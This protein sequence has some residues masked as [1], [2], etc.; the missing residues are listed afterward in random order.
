MF[1]AHF[2]IIDPNF[3]LIENNAYLPPTFLVEDY[4]ARV[5]HLGIS[6]GALVS[7]SFQ[8]FDQSYLCAALRALNNSNFN[9]V[10]V[11]QLAH[12]CSDVQI[13]FL[14]EQGVRALRFNLYRGGSE[15]A[16]YL[17]SLAKRVHSL[18]GWHVELY[19][20]ADSLVELAGLIRRLPSVSI[21][22]LGMEARASL[23]INELVSEGVMVKASGFGRI[24]FDALSRIE[25]LYG[26]NPK[27]LMFGT[28][29]P[30]TRAPRPFKDGDLYLLRDHLS[31]DAY[32]SICFRNG[33]E[34]Y[35]LDSTFSA[36]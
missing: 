18:V 21:D 17:E 14:H 13:R 10:G 8:G 23:V 26:L 19:V 30:S 27:A 15:S 34:F 20:A 3:P 32:Q 11:T 5:S 22:H 12:D 36:A 31:A 2:H 33:R 28:D 16:Q 4:L 29:L 6:S 24:D 1:D 7:G 25:Y 9:F 35:R